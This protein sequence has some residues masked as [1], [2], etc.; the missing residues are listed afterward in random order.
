[1]PVV[2]GDTHE[3]AIEKL[4]YGGDGLAH[5]GSQAVFVPLAA[6]GDRLLVRI[7][8][9][10]RNYARGVIEEIIEASPS[11]RVPP[12]ERF[13]DCGGCQLQHL[14]YAA[15]LEAKVAFVR[16]SLRRIGSIDWD[17]EIAIRSAEE[18][19]YRSR[20]ELKVA[21][22]ST[23]HTRIGYYRPATQE[24]CE[25]EKCLVLIPAANRELHR[26]YTEPSLIP[27]DATRV[28]FTVGDEEVIV[29][30]ATGENG[31]SE[32]VDGLGTAYQRIGGIN[33]GFGVRS[34]FQGNRLLVEELI[35]TAIADASGKLAVDLYAGV[36]LF[37]LQLAKSF[38]QVYA[39]EGNRSAA[40][41]GMD[42]AKANSVSN[43]KYEAVSVE[44]WLK[45]KSVEL[46]C[47]DFVLLD[48]P[49]AGAGAQVMER[50]AAMAAPQISYVSCDP[51]TL[52]RDLRLLMNYGYRI[53]SITALDM[54]PQTFHVETVV[55]LRIAD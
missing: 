40:T 16:E 48:P 29:T 21:H 42:N 17:G 19:G 41:H 26:L 32:A 3:V 37:S 20:A 55:R 27:N 39:V 38:D 4:V 22:D 34:F 33:Y 35:R 46:P 24:V 1:M 53:D 45:Y 31:K 30:P 11:R 49:R 12:C 7:T 51:A 44:A 10:E 36:G 15:Q 5:I 13:G 43:V 50:L 47:P 14:S 18:F 2:T 23:G 8:E 52:A 25:V 9:V 54:F 6:V 28:H